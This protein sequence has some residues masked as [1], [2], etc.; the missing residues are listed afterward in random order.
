VGG[1]QRPDGQP[2]ASAVDREGIHRFGA[3][4]DRGGRPGRIRGKLVLKVCPPGPYG[5]EARAHRL[6]EAGSN[7]AFVER[8]LVK[9]RFDPYRTADGHVLMFQAIAGGSLDDVRPM[10]E[11]S[12]ADLT[13]PCGVVVNSLLTEWS[14][15]VT[16]AET[17]VG[18]YLERELDR[19]REG[20]ASPNR[21]TGNLRALNAGA[22]WIATD[23][24][25]DNHPLPNP[26]LM[27]AEPSPAARQRLDFAAGNAHGDLHLQ[28]VLVPLT[29]V[30]PRP[31]EFRLV[32]LSEFATDAP[33]TR[34]P[35]MLML[36]VIA[37]ELSRLPVPRREALLRL[38]LAPWERGGSRPRATLAMT[39]ATIHDSGQNAMRRHGWLDEWRD[40]FLLSVQAA[41]LL[42]TTFENLGVDERWWFFRLAGHA[43]A[44]FLKRRGAYEPAD[45]QH[46]QMP[47]A[48]NGASRADRGPEPPLR[49]SSDTG[50]PPDIGRLLAASAQ[51]RS[52]LDPREV[53][54]AITR[55]VVVDAVVDSVRAAGDTGAPCVVPVLGEAGIGKTVVTGQIHDALVER[56]GAAVLV[57]PCEHILDPPRDAAGFDIV[58]GQLLDTA[59]GLHAAVEALVSGAGRPVVVLVDTLDYLLDEHT[60]TP[61]V[62]VL[63]RLHRAGAHVVFSCRRHDYSV[64]LMPVPTR[65][66][67]LAGHTTPVNVPPLTDSEIIAIT[68][69]YLQHHQ[70][71]PP[72]G[73][74]RFADTLLMAAAD[75]TPLKDIATNPL[76][77]VMLCDLF[78]SSG[79]VP[80]DLTTTRL[81][82]R[83]CDE[84]ITASRK[85]AANTEMA[86]VKKRLWSHIAG[87]LWRSSGEYLSLSIPEGNLPPD[88]QS[89]RAYE[90]LRS[91][92][93]LVPRSLD[94]QRI[95]FIHQIVTEYSTAIYL[96]DRDP[97]QLGA[98]LA[99]LRRDPAVRWYGWQII[100][101]LIAMSDLEDARRL[102]GQ[103]DLSQPP[104]FRAAALGAVAQ[105]RAGL[106]EDLAAR[107]AF[108]DTLLEALP[109]VPDDA[110]PETLGVVVDVMQRG[111]LAQ[112][113]KAATTAGLL[114]ARAPDAAQPQLV[115]LL[116]VIADIQT[117]RLVI[118]GAERNFP[119][120]LLENLMHPVTSNQRPLSG[121]VLTAARSLMRRTT[122]TGVRVIIRA[123]MIPGTLEDAR[124]DLLGKVLAY[125]RASRIGSEALRLIASVESWATTDSGEPGAADALAFLAKSSRHDRQLRAT[126]VAQAANAWPRMRAPIVAEFLN[127]DDDEVGNRLLICLQQAVK[128]GGSH[129]VASE[130][131]SRP[132]PT[133]PAAVGRTSGLLK[134]F[135]GTEPTVRHALAD[136]FVERVSGMSPGPV[137]AYLRLVH[138]DITRLQL[139]IQHVD[140]LYSRDQER[141]LANL[142]RELDPRQL[143][144]MRLILARVEATANANASSAAVLRARLLGKATATFKEARTD[145]LD[146]VG[147]SFQLAS[148]QALHVLLQ[149]ARAGQAWLV[150]DLVLRFASARQESTR[151]GVLKILDVLLR[152]QAGAA[153]RSVVVWLSRACERRAD[154]GIES[155]AEVSGLL[156][157]GH[158]YLRNGV[159]VDPEALA[160]I[161]QLIED[162]AR[163]L[164]TA[165]VVRRSLLAL[166]KSAAMHP[167]EDLRAGVASSFLQLLDTVDLSGTGEGQAFAR[168]ALG[169]LVQRGHS[170]LSAIVA[171]ARRWAAANQIV[172]VDVIVKQDPKGAR[173]ALLD[174]MLSWDPAERV[175]Q[176]IWEYRLS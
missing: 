47:D 43:G 28:N 158:S 146:L 136:W 129:W 24:D 163:E 109:S 29:G 52:S 124:R 143:Q 137:D 98:L 27:A 115:R 173:S 160:E 17:S 65:L 6:A 85:Y 79:T 76:L 176:A 54:E 159:G 128:N 58:F 86:L 12:D 97:E 51:R 118:E 165:I 11:L 90:D 69:G 49:R 81:C 121:E 80:K 157:L 61:L 172:L 114:V 161:A 53:G 112:V 155:D 7:N 156:D 9:Q 26:M 50:T 36:S 75:R 3:G 134:T 151:I 4:H 148:A 59:A 41:A 15:K 87:E 147:S 164:P 174:E 10:S 130:L 135:A 132:A 167:S 67:R 104:A 32:D 105:W 55:V 106:L 33:L 139:A 142:A 16:V 8:H 166:I 73:A 18:E 20:G 62:Q 107:G 40:Q 116:A 70:V 162:V 72:M 127:T 82:A 25:G 37:Q 66:G 150:P 154:Q 1:D 131:T 60:R 138:D 145:L 13:S 39:L 94:G 93:V 91:E 48:V 23:E 111:S 78:A 89:R 68:K 125:Q 122:P 110:I 35:A 42:F 117:G 108:L 152:G 103:L 141:V 14:P 101:H 57:I 153:D 171:R 99:A 84:K 31:H 77:L 140:V 5:G 168:E 83:Y 175:Q 2:A 144:M 22:A 123:H 46:V 92:G 71:S 102:I 133:M 88:P 126:A 44:E 169:R 74:D 170:Q 113:S 45:P 30:E 64:M 34:D 56:L 96:R 120:Q 63:D 100:R 95:G 38:M 21:W 149:A 19:V 119:D